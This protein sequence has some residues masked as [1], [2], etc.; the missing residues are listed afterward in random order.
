MQKVI[1]KHQPRNYHRSK[2]SYSL[3]GF[4]KRLLFSRFNLYT[5][6]SHHR[7]LGQILRDTCPPTGERTKPPTFH[8]LPCPSHSLR[9]RSLTAF[10][11]KVSGT[12]AYSRT[13]CSSTMYGF[14]ICPLKIVQR[15][16]APSSA[17]TTSN[18][19]FYFTLFLQ[20]IK[21]QICFGLISRFGLHPMIIHSLSVYLNP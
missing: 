7:P 10:S 1:C 5:P 15:L 19:T 2:S 13:M 9:N 12:R 14:G 4:S 6:A 3:L 20:Y 16:Q 11:F 8:A 18:A 17:P 21:R